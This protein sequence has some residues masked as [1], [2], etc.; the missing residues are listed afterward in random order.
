MRLATIGGIPVRTS[1]KGTI[2]RDIRD[3][4]EAKRSRG[5]NRKARVTIDGQAA[6]SFEPETYRHFDR[7]LGALAQSRD[8][9]RAVARL[10]ELEHALM[11]RNSV[12]LPKP[13]LVEQKIDPQHGVCVAVFWGPEGAG[14]TLMATDNEIVSLIG[15]TAGK[16][17]RGV[18]RDLLDAL[19]L[20]SKLSA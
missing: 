15:G 10:F 12:P 20:Q 1:D 19:A 13:R 18:K 17:L 6:A 16:P 9:H 7:Y 11:R 5:D 4:R 8:A 3:Y 2:V 14:I